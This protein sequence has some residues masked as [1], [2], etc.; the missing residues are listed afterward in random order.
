M[1]FQTVWSFCLTHIPWG[2]NLTSTRVLFRWG[3]A[4]KVGSIHIHC[5][6]H[7]ADKNTVD[8]SCNWK[9]EISEY[10][11]HNDSGRWITTSNYPLRSTDGLTMP[12]DLHDEGVPQIDYFG[13]CIDEYMGMLYETTMHE[14]MIHDHR[15]NYLYP[16]HLPKPYTPTTR[17][18]S[19]KQVSSLRCF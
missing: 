12:Y 19:L 16:P 6:K 1:Q 15:H 9:P 3:S 4:E 8:M 18:V 5:F 11:Y 7:K 2:I 17:F 10:V 13:G 14:R